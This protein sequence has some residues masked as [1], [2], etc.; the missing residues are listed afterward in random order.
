MRL[1]AYELCAQTQV[2]AVP[3]QVSTNLSGEEIIL[4]LDTGVY[5]GLDHVGTRIW[6]LVQQTN[7]VGAICAIICDEYEIDPIQCQQDVQQFL[8]ALAEARLVEV[9]HDATVDATTA[10]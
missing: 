4:L 1:M 9:C 2:T 3:G 7:T 5:Y 8:L 6:A 10:C